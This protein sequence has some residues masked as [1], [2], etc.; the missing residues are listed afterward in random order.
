MKAYQ[1][2]LTLPLVLGCVHVA[3]SFKPNLPPLK[4]AQVLVIGASGQVG[5]KVCPSV[6]GMVAKVAVVQTVVVVR[7]LCG[8][9]Q[10]LVELLSGGTTW[11]VSDCCVSVDRLLLSLCVGV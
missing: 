9:F 7:R 10:V 3:E 4:D 5:E 1:A 11:C 2:A 6:C 8:S